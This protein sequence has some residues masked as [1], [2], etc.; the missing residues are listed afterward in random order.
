MVNTENDQFPFLVKLIE[1]IKDFL[2]N[3]KYGKKYEDLIQTSE[4]YPN[5]K[6][7]KLHSISTIRFAAYMH[8][9]CTTRFAAYMHSV[10]LALLK[11][12][13]VIVESLNERS[14]DGD[15]G[16]TSLLRRICNVEFITLLVEMVDVYDILAKSFH[17]GASANDQRI[18]IYLKA[19]VQDVRND[20]QSSKYWPTINAYW[21]L[22]KRNELIKDL[23][24]S[25]SIAVITLCDLSNL[26]L[27]NRHY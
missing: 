16:A 12:L 25:E 27:V 9:V 26:L 8:S 17:M 20:T 18:Y 5:E 22:L 24:V 7:Y 21:P 23:P 10:L 11:D 13:K 3:A 4:K 2:S 6:C 1:T 15:D 19:M 14:K